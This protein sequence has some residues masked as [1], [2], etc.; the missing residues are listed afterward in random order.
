MG[1]AFQVIDENKTFSSDLANYFKD[2]NL[3]ESGLNYHLVSVFGS[4]STGKST[5]L[6]ALFDTEFG[7]MDEKARG[8]TTK[9]I[10]MGAASQKS[11][12]SKA[13]II[14]LDV[15]GTDGRER[16]EDQDFERKA[17]LFALATSEVLIVNM[18]ESQVGLYQGANMGLLKTVF[19][20]NLSLF[21]AANQKSPKSRILFVI[22]D[23]LGNTPL[24][25]LAETLL[26]DLNKHWHSLAKPS[27]ELENSKISDFFDIDFS[28]LPHKVLLPE[29]FS[30]TV[31]HLRERFLDET[32]KEFVFNEDYHRN[33][34]LDGWP[35]YA[36]QIWEQI[37][38]NK[39]LDLPT[40]QILVARFRCVDIANQAWIQFNS[41]LEQLDAPFG[42]DTLIE[43][44]G[45][46]LGSIRTKALH[47]YDELASRYTKTIYAENRFELL[48]KIDGLLTSYYRSQLAAIQTS[49]LAI[50]WASLSKRDPSV[51]F[52][53]SLLAVE[54]FAKESYHAAALEATID[55]DFYSF[56]VEEATFLDVLSSEVSKA[57]K[58]EMATIATK[59]GKQ[60]KRQ[61]GAK[62][63]AILTSADENTWD[64]V[65]KLME[66]EISAIL[67]PYEGGS[68]FHLGGDARD[69]AQGKETVEKAAWAAL[70][71]QLKDYTREEWLMA[72][73]RDRFEDKFRYDAEG[74]PVVWTQGDDVQ[75][76]YIRSR[77]HALLLLPVLSSA[78]L[79]DGTV[80]RKPEHLSSENDD[81]IDYEEL[82]DP[83]TAES[84]RA[85]F[86]RFADTAF[87]DAKRAVAQS[88]SH[89]PYYM[90]LIILVL[91]WNEFM[92]VL[93]NPLLV[94]LLLMLGTS[95]YF[96]VSMNLGGPVLSVA[97]AMIQRVTEEAK[98]RAR[99]YLIE[100]DNREAPIELQD[101]SKKENPKQDETTPASE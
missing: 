34:P 69:N 65:Q 58:Q 71:A 43:N 70:D 44:F 18:W 12:K 35:M 5:L 29:K 83:A 52:S 25:N 82:V 72:R 67:V 9:G 73:L 64:K 32:H 46:P 76:A 49:V 24:E 10:W 14:I 55:K 53:K 88:A 61:L 19:E 95:A 84:L 74:I 99:E 33:V 97:D 78:K 31:D 41:D 16:G 47:T 81:E 37:E 89:V 7:V 42:T 48:G 93:R 101:L 62:L 4:Q 75:A 86:K 63:P 28:T 77:D 8:Q 54:M 22:R 66:T 26:A 79:Q 39:D 96:V 59:L 90:W 87:V 3:A 30:E 23:F 15:E 36:S 94:V 20:V 38:L 11:S 2:A 80:L 27:P 17:A 92:M 13:D 91:G 56:S 98:K 6:N 68:D 60:V 40:Q 100:Q 57:R 85:Q 50:F 1:K 21:Q 45:P 51:P